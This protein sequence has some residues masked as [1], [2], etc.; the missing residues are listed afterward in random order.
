MDDAT[1]RKAGRR[2]RENNRERL[3]EKESCSLNWRS[4]VCQ[5]SCVS[6]EEKG[7]TQSQQHV[8]VGRSAR[9]GPLSLS[10]FSVPTG[11]ERER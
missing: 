11:G 4:R 6:R 8:V 5:I 3:E 1:L 10:V 2:T 9:L 7:E